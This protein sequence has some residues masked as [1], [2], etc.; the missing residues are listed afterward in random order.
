M[1]PDKKPSVVENFLLK[2]LD[3]SRMSRLLQKVLQSHRQL[4]YSGM[5]MVLLT[6]LK[7]D[8]LTGRINR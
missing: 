6:D 8:A 2:F 4:K 5:E 1:T 3:V 7:C